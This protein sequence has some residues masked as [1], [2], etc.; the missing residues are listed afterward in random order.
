M[1]DYARPILINMW[2]LLLFGTISVF[3]LTTSLIRAC[4]TKDAY[5][6][7]TLLALI[8][9]ANVFLISNAI[10]LHKSEQTKF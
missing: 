6:I 9:L 8:I 5:F 3:F 7:T 4:R 10:L 1:S 2:L